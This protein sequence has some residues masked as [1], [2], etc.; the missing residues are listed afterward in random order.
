MLLLCLLL[1]AGHNFMANLSKNHVISGIRWQLR[2]KITNYSV[3]RLHSSTAVNLD[4]I[5]RRK[6][7][8]EQNSISRR[9]LLGEFFFVIVLR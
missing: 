6:P 3:D 2:P 9:T 4:P 5:L 7:R 8:L 1:F